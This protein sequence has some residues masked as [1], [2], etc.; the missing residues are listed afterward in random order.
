MCVLP[1]LSATAVVAQDA[2][3]DTVKPLKVTVGLAYLNASG[4][5]DVTSLTFN[6]RIEWKRPR[7]LWTQSAN[8][9]I[10]DAAS[11]KARGSATR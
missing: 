6:E 8:A 4:N 9:V 11:R 7:F 5:T 2:K 1:L 3:P 10:S